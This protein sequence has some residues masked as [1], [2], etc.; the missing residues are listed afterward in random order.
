MPQERE[1]AAAAVHN[2]ILTGLPRPDL[3]LVL[4][5]LRAVAF[6]AG[7]ELESRDP[8]EDCLFIEAGMV[9]LRCELDP[10]GAVEVSLVGREG[11]LGLQALLGSMPRNHCATAI[12]PGEALAIRLGELRKLWPRS[13]RLQARLLHYAGERLGQAGRRSA[14]HL[15]HRLEERLADWILAVTDSLGAAKVAITHKQ[16]STLLGST[17]PGVTL[18]IQNL[19]GQLAIRATRNLISVRSRE[20]LSDLSCGCCGVD[21]QHGAVLHPVAG[22]A[23]AAVSAADRA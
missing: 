5:L 17:R 23:A 8:P 13:V 10:T 4:P 16:L 22:K 6:D 12:T 18:A 7:Q 14:C 19:E 11:M 2:R 9:S 20:A 15:Q 21:R 1:A 3:D